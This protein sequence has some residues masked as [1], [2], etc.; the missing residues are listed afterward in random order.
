MFMHLK[1]LFPLN[2]QSLGHIE[3]ALNLKH[4]KFAL[5][6]HLYDVSALREL[7]LAKKLNICGISYVVQF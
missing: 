6:L 3:N 1:A 5:T 4:K 2:V 7:L